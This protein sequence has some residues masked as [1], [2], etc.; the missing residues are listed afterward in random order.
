MSY[1][2]PR[3]YLRGLSSGQASCFGMPHMG[4]DYRNATG[5]AHK[6]ESGLHCVRCR[7]N[8]A[9][10]AHH[11]PPKG[12]GGAKRTFTL[13][14]YQM[15]PALLALCAECHHERHQ[16]MYTIRWKWFEPDYERMWW[17]GELF[18]EGYVPHDPRLY[19]LGEWEF[20]P[21]KKIRG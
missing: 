15:R 14:G 10:Q 6:L 19:D 18:A 8:P 20:E 11:E 3:E 12:M 1:E 9:E 4:A 16:M 17:E 7:L 2:I 21:R 5:D 13:H